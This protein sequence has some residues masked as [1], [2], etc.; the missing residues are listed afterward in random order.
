[1]S[2]P[3]IEV[4]P[5]REA[6]AILGIKVRAAEG[7]LRH[8]GIRSGYPRVAVEW[9]R[10]HRPGPG[11]RTD[12]RA[13]MDPMID[14]YSLDNLTGPDADMRDALW[15]AGIQIDST[16]P[17]G[18]GRV[19]FEI[20]TADGVGIVLGGEPSDEDPDGTW[21]IARRNDNESFLYE[22]GDLP[23]CVAAVAQATSH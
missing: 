5:L 15:A 8:A 23:G 18:D 7:A 1:M 14:T 12:K 3:N 20:P 17:D 16:H 11:A 19:A 22:G 2:R 21:W 13:A 10:D 6:A 4:V 9:L